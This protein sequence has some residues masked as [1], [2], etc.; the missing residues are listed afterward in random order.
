MALPQPHEVGDDLLYLFVVGPGT[1]ETVLLRIPPQQWMIIDSFRCGTPSRAAA[2]SIISR[3]GSGEKVAVLAL[4]HPHQDHYPGLVDLID[5]YGDAI[6]GCVYPRATNTTDALANDAMAALEEG[7]KP[8][9]TRIWDE[10]TKDA[11]RRWDTFRGERRNVGEATVTSLHPTR[12]VGA[13]QW[14]GDLNALSSAMLVEW[15]GLRILLGADVPGTEWPGI[16][17]TFRRLSEHSAMKVPHHGSRAAIHEVFGEGTPGRFWVITPFQ[18]S[19]LPRAA[20]CTPS[21][22]PEGLVQALSF[23]NELR[24]TS[25]PFRHERESDDPCAA[26]RAQIRD[27]T[28]PQRLQRP[29]GDIMA[30]ASALDRQIVVAFDRRGRVVQE[31]YGRGSARVTQ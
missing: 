12:P 11:E 3:Y 16:G 27:G 19:K 9:F 23:V 18:K 25:L 31:W 15:H 22:E 4:T 10:W 21:G 7:A 13:R 8:T 2:E 30:S 6:L 14:A 26:T 20:D 29:N 24:L 1:G 28:H 5:R 17:A